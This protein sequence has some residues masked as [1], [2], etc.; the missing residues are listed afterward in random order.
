MMP[1]APARLSTTICCPMDFDTAGPRMRAFTST[2]PPGGNGEIMR[3]AW[4]GYFAVCAHAADAPSSATASTFVRTLFM[5]FP[6]L[7]FA[8]ILRRVTKDAKD[9][10]KALLRIAKAAK[11]ARGRNVFQGRQDNAK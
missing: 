7:G 4:S 9:A 1:D 10:K 8:P 2:V 3:I 6:P 11:D 5:S